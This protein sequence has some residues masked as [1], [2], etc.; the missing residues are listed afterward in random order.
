MRS[1]RPFLRLEALSN[2]LKDVGL[3]K[4][5]ENLA[6]VRQTLA[7]VT[8]RLAAFEAEALNVQI[9]FPLFQRY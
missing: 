4:S 5:L 1:S 3:K 9:E 7:A 2:K 6:A 8:D